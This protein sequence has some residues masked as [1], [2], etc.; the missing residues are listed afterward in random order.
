MFIYTKNTSLHEVAARIIGLPRP[1]ENMT[2]ISVVA[3][4]FKAFLVRAI[5]SADFRY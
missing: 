2:A 5:A 1:L 3:N 4:K